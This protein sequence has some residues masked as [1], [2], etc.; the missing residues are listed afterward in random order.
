MQL[1]IS[2]LTLQ[3]STSR[4]E[5]VKASLKDAS[6]RIKSMMVLYD[7]LYR[8]TDFLNLSISR[9]ISYLIEGIRISYPIMSSAAIETDIDE[10]EIN[11]GSI[12]TLGILMNELVTNSVKYALNENS[13]GRLKISLKKKDQSIVLTV[14][15][16]GPGLPENFDLNHTAGFGL[17]L[18]KILVKQLK[19]E[20][21]A[22][23]RQ[24]AEFE[25]IFPAE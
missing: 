22:R 1:I 8:T 21:T 2:L 7:R 5:Q 16:N 9:Y 17:H 20:M 3:A 19:G 18:I 13:Q 25:I 6:S 10:I 24:G 4:E 23:N 14:S 12:S 11:A 15:D